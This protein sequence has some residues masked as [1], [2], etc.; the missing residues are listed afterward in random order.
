[1]EE[2]DSFS[3]SISSYSISKDSDETREELLS[4][5]FNEE[6]ILSRPQSL[7]EKISIYRESL[8]SLKSA[9]E[10]KEES[11]DLLKFNLNSLKERIS[12]K[13]TELLSI[14]SSI[15]AYTSELETFSVQ[16]RSPFA[17]YPSVKILLQQELRKKNL[18]VQKAEIN[19][20]IKQHELLVL[21]EYFKSIKKLEDV[22][23][24]EITW[25]KEMMENRK[26]I[27]ESSRN[28]QSYSNEKKYIQKFWGFLEESYEKVMK[29]SLKI[30]SEQLKKKHKQIVKAEYNFWSLNKV[31]IESKAG[32]NENY[33]NQANLI[34]ESTK[35]RLESSHCQNELKIFTLKNDIN[36]ASCL[37]N[38]EFSLK[39]TLMLSVKIYQKQLSHLQSRVMRMRKKHN[40]LQKKIIKNTKKLSMIELRLAKLKSDYFLK[41]L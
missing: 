8:H 31:F 25:V 28:W 14:C 38:V 21:K 29:Q 9:L 10:T 11:V 20:S 36:K 13:D 12:T 1:M 7:K 5:D 40:K 23:L 3:S 15:S 17:D 30:M 16:K 39:P 32:I 4:L 18:E 37:K 34:R 41:D 6:F 24:L 26:K 2:Y 19:L 27:I 22:E 35:R 33:T